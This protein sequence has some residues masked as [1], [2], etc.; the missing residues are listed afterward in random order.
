MH[1]SSTA[2]DATHELVELTDHNAFGRGV[3]YETFAMLRSDDPV[4]WQEEDA[5]PGFWC[6]TRHEHITEVHKNPA[7]FSSELGGTSLEDISPE[8]LEARKSMLD[9]DPPRHGKLRKLISKSFTPKAV[10]VYDG[11]IRELF[12]SILDDAL[13]KAEV[14]FVADVSAALPMRVFAEILGAPP[15]DHR[16]L[17]EIGDRILGVSD[18]EYAPEQD[19][20]AYAHL[21]FS[22]PAALDMFD[23]G[24]R[25]ADAR[26][27]EPRDDIVTA[28]LTAEI[29]GQPLTARE[30]DVYFLLLAAAGNE[31]TRHA[32]SHGMLAYLEHPDQRRRLLDDPSLARSA[33]DEV[34]RWATPV[35]HFRRTVTTDVE[36]HGKQ[37]RAG[38]KLATW[39]VS[40]NR[41]ERVFESPERFDIGRSPNPHLSFGP[42]NIHFCVGAHLA[43]L[44]IQ[45]FFEEFFARVGEI[46]LTGPVERL[47]SNFFNGIKRMPVRLTGPGG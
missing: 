37:L 42:P 44:E 43:R 36:F 27:R 34:L 38:D 29:D 5:G 18:P 13:A 15:E 32:I 23:Y 4:H 47:R 3:P 17:V 7:I 12:A 1:R 46:E 31:T 11:R 6:I 25:L 39:L 28:L 14:D 20:S 33:A 8:N 21:P 9:T 35:H 19:R 40:G 30:Y 24:R 2:S 41:D 45:I 16:T 10:E 26:R 22:T